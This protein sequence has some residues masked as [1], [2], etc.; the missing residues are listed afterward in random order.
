[1]SIEP[2]FAENITIEK[3][4]YSLD[5]SNHTAQVVNVDRDLGF[6]GATSSIT[7]ANIRA[8]ITFRGVS[9]RVTSI[10]KEAFL[11]CRRLTIATI[12]NS[13]QIIGESV[14]DQCEALATVSIG[15]GEIKKYAFKGCVHLQSLILNEG[16]TLIGEGAFEGTG[17]TTLTIP[18]SVTSIG[19]NA[20]YNSKL[21]SIKVGNGVKKIENGTFRGTN[22]KEFVIPQN[23]TCIGEFAFADCKSLTRIIIHKNVRQIAD[24]AF[25]DCPS[26]QSVELSH[27]NL[28]YT[29]VE[30]VLFNKN[31]TILIQYPSGRKNTSYNIPEGVNE[32][33]NYAF[34]NVPNLRNIQ[35]SN[36]VEEIG[37]GNFR[38]CKNLK[39]LKIG[40]NV[41]KIGGFVC[42]SCTSLTDFI[43]PSSVEE[44]GD[45][46]FEHCGELVSITIP[47]NVQYVG[48]YAFANCP[49]L[50]L[51][52]P[53]HTHCHSNAF[54][55]SEDWIFYDTVNP[56]EERK[57]KQEETKR[58]QIELEKQRQLELQYQ[59]EQEARAK[60]IQQEE[61]E[62]KRKI[63]QA[64]KEQERQAAYAKWAREYQDSIKAGY[65]RGHECV[66]LGLSVVWA[67]CNVGA[68]KPTKD[69]KLVKRGDAENMNVEKGWRLPTSA[70]CR[71]LINNCTI[72]PIGGLIYKS[73]LKVTSKKNGNSIV[74]P[75]IFGTVSDGVC[76]QLWTS[77]GSVLQWIQKDYGHQGIEHKLDIGYCS[78]NH[79]KGVI[80][81]VI[82]KKP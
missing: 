54:I 61:A 30:G 52:V 16:V 69:G 73:H 48:G 60:R 23:V 45:H 80:R 18:N 43:I 6:G 53:R 41:K 57:K 15:S 58:R 37:R 17:I 67:T 49:S 78:Q 28:Y 7:N 3:I 59:K 24:G 19:E 79:D 82:S 65:V 20:F 35:I 42:N 55:N 56:K 38:N 62:Q 12:P 81:C 21:Q 75:N 13:V 70:E 25:S 76:A 71:E 10:R 34:N 32:V 27:E 63:E 44:I 4:I 66:D 40:N 68:S 31:K 33:A 14:F 8:S 72:K 47:G 1:M 50:T 74:I 51:K 36:S 2:L 39:T 11:N 5:D 26:L 9:Y 64:R 22:L 46:A 77:S 29:N